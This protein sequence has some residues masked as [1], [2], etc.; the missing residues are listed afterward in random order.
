MVTKING[1]SSGFVF[2]VATISASG[3]GP[4]CDAYVIKEWDKYIL[5][6]LIDGLGHGEDAALASTAAKEYVTDNFK[7]GIEEIMTGLYSPLSK[8]RG[9]VIGLAL[10]DKAEKRFAFCGVGNIEVKVISHPPMHPTSLE[11]IVGMNKPR[12]RKFEYR[13]ENLGAV[14]LYS[15][16]ISSKFELQSPFLQPQQMAEAILRKWWNRF[17]DATVIIAMEEPTYR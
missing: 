9:A 4:N 11:G 2:G 6:A 8:T 14:A 3:K 16:G 7:S 1:S 5:I 17:D 12:L 15:D 10:I 13:Y